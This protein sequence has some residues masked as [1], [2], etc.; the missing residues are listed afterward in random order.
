[1]AQHN[2]IEP[3]AAS[4]APVQRNQQDIRAHNQTVILA[5][6]EEEFV[7]QGFRGA[8]MQGIADRAIVPLLNNRMQHCLVQIFFILK[9]VMHVGFWQLGSIGNTLHR[10]TAKTLQHELLF[11]RRQN[12]G[13]IV[14]ADIL[15]I[16][17]Y[18][19][20][21]RGLWFYIVMLSHDKCYLS[22]L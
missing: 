7:L 19:R 9:V 4:D 14:G 18:R 15:L 1:M 2:D 16:A 3:Q 21:R 11:C 17:L 22:L 12:D 5:A 10:R 8:T 13:L 20:V 6:A